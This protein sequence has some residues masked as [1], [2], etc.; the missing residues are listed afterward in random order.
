M[1]GEKKLGAACLSR[2]G[3]NDIRE[4]LSD[5]VE[6]AMSAPVDNSVLA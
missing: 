6:S 3:E 4:L 5:L 1:G 2:L